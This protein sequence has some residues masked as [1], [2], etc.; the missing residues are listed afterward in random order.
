MNWLEDW[1]TLRDDFIQSIVTEFSQDFGVSGFFSNP[2]E[3]HA[4]VQEKVI[5][6]NP[7]LTDEEKTL[8]TLCSNGALE[9]TGGN[10]RE[11]ALIYWEKMRNCVFDLTDDEDLYN[12]FDIAVDA[13]ESATVEGQIQ[14]TP[15]TQRKIPLWV[16]ALPLAFLFFRRR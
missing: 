4:W 15:K 9:S 14:N 16:Y 1:L 7:R 11:A 2:Y 5:D 12:L 6:P 3:A 8:L 10:S 13:A